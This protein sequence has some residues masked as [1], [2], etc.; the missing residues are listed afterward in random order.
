MYV[1]PREPPDLPV[2]ENVRV[3]EVTSTTITVGWDPVPGAL[4][5]TTRYKRGSQ[6]Y[7]DLLSP[8][9]ETTITIEDLPPWRE[10]TIG[11]QAVGQFGCSVWTNDIIVV[12]HVSDTDPSLAQAIEAVAEEVPHAVPLPALAKLLD[13]VERMW[14]DENS[15]IVYK[16]VR[17]DKLG[18]V[19]LATV[20]GEDLV[21]C[22]AIRDNVDLIVTDMTA[23]RGNTAVSPWS[24]E[25]A[26][27]IITE[28]TTVLLAALPDSP[29]EAEALILARI[30][31]KQLELSALSFFRACHHREVLAAQGHPRNGSRTRA[32]EILG[33]SPQTITDSQF[34]QEQRHKR[35][36]QRHPPGNA[37]TGGEGTA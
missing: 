10:V 30:R 11:V 5:Y 8:R 24:V 9:A 31:R 23:P 18:P 2:P 6:P 14:I 28:C 21:S 7:Y 27:Q 22:G 29:A 16:I 35:Y 37:S 17:Y 25:E 34:S 20:D 33:V 32:A 26:K 19:S 1:I 4:R 36:A 13:D 15:G 12:T 3:V